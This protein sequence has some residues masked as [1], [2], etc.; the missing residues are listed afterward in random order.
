MGLGIEVLEP[1]KNDALR[2]KRGKNISFF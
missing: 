1:A 2:G